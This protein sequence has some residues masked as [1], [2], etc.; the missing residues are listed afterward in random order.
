M[1]STHEVR[2]KKEKVGGGAEGGREGSQVEER[3]GRKDGRAVGRVRVEM[4]M[5]PRGV[6]RAVG[7]K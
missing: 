6:T 1:S 7:V 2:K 5:A 3:E 4:E